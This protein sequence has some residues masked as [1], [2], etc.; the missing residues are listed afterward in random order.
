MYFWSENPEVPEVSLNPLIPF[1]QTYVNYVLTNLSI[2]FFLNFKCILNQTSSIYM[3][4]IFAHLYI[5]KL[6]AHIYMSAIAGQ[7]ACPKGLTFFERTHACPKVNKGL[8]NFHF[9]LPNFFN[10]TDS[11]WASLYIFVFMLAIAGQTAGRN[12]LIFLLNSKN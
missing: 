7:M 11:A 1:L 3:I 6:F 4:K 8:I 12:L 2:Y 9:F 10:A 5:I